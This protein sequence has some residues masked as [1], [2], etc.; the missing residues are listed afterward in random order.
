MKYSLKTIETL[1]KRFLSKPCSIFV[2]NT[3]MSFNQVQAQDYFVGIVESI[4]EDG[5]FTKHPITNCWNFFPMDKIL[6]ICEEQM[7]NPGN[8]EDAKIIDKYKKQSE[9]KQSTAP[10]DDGKFLSISSMEEMIK[11]SKES[12]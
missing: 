6:G 8:P 2:Q 3:N 9:E 10:K 12:T 11:K 4:D 7:L 1:K 5:I